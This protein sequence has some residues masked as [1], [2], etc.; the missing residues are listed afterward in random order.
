M[1]KFFEDFNLIWN[2]ISNNENFVHARYADGEVLLMRG[3]SV[4]KNTQAF[5]VDKWDA[6]DKLTLVGKELLE[7]LN[8]EEKNYFYAISGKNDSPSDYE[9]LTERIKQN[10]EHITFANL[11][12]N[13][14][15]QKMMMRYEM[16]NR[17]VILICN[18]NAKKENFPFNVI[19]IQTF[20][21]NCIEFWETNSIEYINEL[22]SRFG[23]IE[24]KLF[25][26]SCGPVSEIII[27]KLYLNNQNNAYVDVG[28]SID[29][30]VHCRK[31]RP[32]MNPNT[33]YANQ[34]S[35]F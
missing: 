16:I 35:I 19:D 7:T 30:F 33:P 3:T 34:I 18:E 13:G 1:E 27:H 29:E 26:I 14:N 21:N 10:K 5:V 9:F 12:I 2:L 23:Q 6:P 11:W 20:P 22:I 25:L 17:E 8:H 4:N 31:T 24:N 15:Y 32:Y 28:S